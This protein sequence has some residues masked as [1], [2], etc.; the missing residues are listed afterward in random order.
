[1]TTDFEALAQLTPV[2]STPDSGFLRR[3]S[4]KLAIPYF[5]PQKA[6]PGDEEHL[7]QSSKAIPDFDIETVH[8]GFQLSCKSVLETAQEFCHK[9][10]TKDVRIDLQAM[11]KEVIQNFVAEIRPLGVHYKT[12][13]L[14][15]YL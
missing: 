6:R 12:L 7:G 3:M 14:A 5:S 9:K 15:D 1:M 13:P 4:Q 10:A 8:F 2:T 11:T